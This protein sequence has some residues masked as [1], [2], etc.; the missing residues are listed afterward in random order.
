MKFIGS[1]VVEFNRLELVVS[2]SVIVECVSVISEE[3]V[4]NWPV[5][6]VLLDE[7][8][9]GFNVVFT[10]RV[11]VLEAFS[12]GWVVVGTGNVVLTALLGSVVFSRSDKPGVL[13]WLLQ[14]ESIIYPNSCSG[15]IYI[16][17]VCICIKL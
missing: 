15:Y 14:I 7:D 9:K 16:Y 6:V 17:Y 5:A 10:R 11:V 4:V 13:T 12:S 3:G 2:E 1:T 8:L